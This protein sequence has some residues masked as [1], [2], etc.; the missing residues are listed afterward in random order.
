MDGH[1]DE[2]SIDTN[3]T[4]DISRQDLAQSTQCVWQLIYSHGNEL[5]KE[6]GS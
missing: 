1:V 2:T 4:S 6:K 3:K 5:V